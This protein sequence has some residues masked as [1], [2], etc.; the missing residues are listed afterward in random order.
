[1]GYWDTDSIRREREGKLD[2]NMSKEQMLERILDLEVALYPLASTFHSLDGMGD[3]W[4]SELNSNLIPN[5]DGT[6]KKIMVSS[7]EK[8]EYVDIPPQDTWHQIEIVPRCGKDVKN[9]PKIHDDFEILS[10]VM[11][12]PGAGGSGGAITMEDVRRATKILGFKS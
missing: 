2:R 5:C 6:L 11:S 9:S 1:M 10:V 3:S 12:G 4:S 8:T 7:P